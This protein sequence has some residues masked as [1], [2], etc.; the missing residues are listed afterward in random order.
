MQHSASPGSVRPAAPRRTVAVAG[1]M[2][3]VGVLITVFG[4]PTQS[5]GAAT[6]DGATVSTVSVNSPQAY[7][8]KAPAGGTDDYHC[9]LVDPHLTKNSFIVSSQFNPGTGA[10]A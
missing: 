4:V 6:A 7:T 5:S 9:T 10:A 1:V 3:A 2:V 8:P